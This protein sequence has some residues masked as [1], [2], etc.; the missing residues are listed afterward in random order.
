MKTD[1]TIEGTPTPE[2]LV[3]IDACLRNRVPY[4]WRSPGTM[5]IAR[6]GAPDVLRDVSSKGHKILGFDGFELEGGF[7]RPRMDLTF[8]QER[9]PGADPLDI[10]ASWP[11]DPSPNELWI[12]VVLQLAAANLVDVTKDTSH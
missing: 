6:S 7:I 8:D 12:D 11:N 2:Q 4:S 9:Q 1:P 5:L 10:V 3:L